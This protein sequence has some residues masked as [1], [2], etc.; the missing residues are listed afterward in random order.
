MTVLATSAG[1]FRKARESPGKSVAENLMMNEVC[2]CSIMTV[3]R[4][5]QE[6]RKVLV[7]G[8]VL[9]DLRAPVD[10]LTC[11]K[12]LVRFSTMIS[13]HEYINKYRDFN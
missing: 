1:G 8:E 12:A 2:N 3:T 10:G 11:T 6:I 7:P 4:W 13:K 5:M 9:R